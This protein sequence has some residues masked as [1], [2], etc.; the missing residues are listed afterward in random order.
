LFLYRSA[1][2]NNDEI[3]KYPAKE[4]GRSSLKITTKKEKPKELAPYKI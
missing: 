2:E 3:A 1:T 4:R